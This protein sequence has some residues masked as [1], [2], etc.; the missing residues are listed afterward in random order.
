MAVAAD[1]TA[2][3]CVAAACMPDAFTEGLEGFMAA[4][5]AMPDVYTH[6]IRSLVD[7]S[8]V[9]PAILSPVSPVMVG[10]IAGVGWL[11]CRRCGS[12][13][14]PTVRMAIWQP[15]YYD[16]YGQYICPQYPYQY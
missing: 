5:V 6:R 8:P 9:V 1:F 3:A 4:A 14:S 10:D 7:P 13:R 15:C 11:W 2:A 12:S 16:A